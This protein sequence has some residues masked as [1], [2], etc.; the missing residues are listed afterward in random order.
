MGKADTAMH[1][2]NRRQRIAAQQAAERRAQQRNRLLLAGGAI[3]VVVAVVL[4]VVLL[5]GGGGS[6]APAGPAAPTGAALTKLVGQ[7]SSV[8][9]SALD[10]VGAGT[11]S[12][13]PTTISGAP[14]TSGG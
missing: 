12:A 1:E 3:V 8:P 4:T 7:V 13:P 9:A 11:T 2:G 6:S 5:Q 14:L 10:Q